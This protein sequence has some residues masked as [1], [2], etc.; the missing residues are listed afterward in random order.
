MLI[1][2]LGGFNSAY[3][4]IFPFAL[5]VGFKISNTIEYTI[6]KPELVP[7]PFIDFLMVYR[8]DRG[9]SIFRICSSLS[10]FSRLGKWS[11]NI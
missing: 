7:A 3:A 6:K 4:V 1:A 2:A 11:L 8:N 10:V 5:G 9:Y